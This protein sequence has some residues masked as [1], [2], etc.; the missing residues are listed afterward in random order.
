MYNHRLTVEYEDCIYESIIEDSPDTKNTLL[1]WINDFNFPEYLINDM[2]MKI[3][4]Y[5][6]QLDYDCIFMEGHRINKL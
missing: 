3:S 4:D 6:R 2:R 1:I 5:F